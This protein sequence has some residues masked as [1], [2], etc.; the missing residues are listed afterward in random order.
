MASSAMEIIPA[1]ALRHARERRGE[2]L[3]RMADRTR[4]SVQYLAA[5]ESDAPLQAF[6]SP[7]YA[8]LF[9]RTY[10][11]DLGLQEEPL[12]SE[13]SRRHGADRLPPAG[14]PSAAPAPK[15]PSASPSHSGGGIIETLSH[16]R[17]RASARARLRLSRASRRSTKLRLGHRTMSPGPGWLVAAVSVALVV[18]VAVPLVALSGK[19]RKAVPL[20]RVASPAPAPELPWG[21]RVILPGH[22]IVA[23][24]GSARTDALGVLGGGTPDQEAAKLIREAKNYELGTTPVV[25]TFE[26]I[27]TVASFHPGPDGQYR[28]RSDAGIIQ[29]YLDAI[30]RVKGLLVLDIQPGRADFLTEVKQYEVFLKEPDVGLALDGEWHV[31][32]AE[33]PGVVIGTVDGE[34]VNRVSEYLSGIVQR[35]NLPQKLFVI[36]QFT[37]SEITHRNR[38][39]TNRPGLATVL[40]IDGYGRPGTKMLKYDTLTLRT[41]RFFHGIKLYYKQDPDLLPPLTVLGLRPTPDVIIYQ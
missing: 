4:I 29:G 16:P 22:R 9:L 34:T 6:P 17:K 20:R 10:A 30:R 18:A 24:Y 36:H 23:Y 39:I 21:G 26:L 19:G 28:F 5:L 25:P 38:I 15:W 12:V 2:S 27:A 1:L 3:D 40:D 31:G 41:N 13:F 11:R 7:M 35:Y 33:V 37:P 14:L 32:P 8:R